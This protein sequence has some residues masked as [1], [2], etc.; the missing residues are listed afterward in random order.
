MPAARTNVRTVDPA[1]LIALWFA[2]H[3]GDPVPSEVAVDETG[4]LVALALDSHL[5]AT[6]VG[7]G[8]LTTEELEQRLRRLG[9][10]PTTDPNETPT[11]QA[12][13]VQTAARDEA[14]GERR[15]RRKCYRIRV[16]DHYEWTCIELP[17]WPPEREPE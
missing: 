17:P 12:G 6:L 14:S 15:G 9:I 8:R 2:I 4:Y 16:E 13:A 11:Q 3:G 7:G 10:E 5:A 1:A